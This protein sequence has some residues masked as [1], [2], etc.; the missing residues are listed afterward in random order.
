M[1]TQNLYDTMTMLKA[2]EQMEREYRFLSD[3]FVEDGSV[4][5]DEHP[6]YDYRKGSKRGL[7]P[8][9]VPGT[10]G[11]TLNRDKF[12]MRQIRFTT[13]EP[14]YVIEESDLEHRQFG[15][16]VIGGDSQET[17]SKK[18]LAQDLK[19]LRTVLQNTRDWMARE[20]LLNGKLEIRRHTR[21]GQE[22]V[23]T[24]V[25]DFGFTNYYV[26][27]TKWDQAGAKIHYDME[28][29]FDLVYD[30]LGEIDIL[31]MGAGVFEAMTENST[32]LKTLDM[33][34]LYMGE[35]ATKYA[36]SG[37]RYRGTNSDGV[38]M[39][40]YSGHVPTYSGEKPAIPNGWILAGSSRNKPIS[41]MHGPINK[42]SGMDENA[43]RKTYIKK[44][45]PFRV[46]GSHSD[47][48]ATQMISRPT[49]VPQNVG[50]WAVMKVLTGA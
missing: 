7:A 50:A 22:K 24:M 8:F 1:P 11:V 43:T 47:S 12:E 19:N 18:L 31:V 33:D 34:K 35:I 5:A 42:W 44:E 10:G 28:K 9:V 32:Y 40:S 27:A 14:Q 16:N 17:R 25:A 49:V 29:V 45:V 13:L 37:V 2:V 48:I 6:F 39:V 26:P 15:E 23:P 38:K 41:F 46:G 36:G 30:Q 3:T 20:V 21:A 4:S